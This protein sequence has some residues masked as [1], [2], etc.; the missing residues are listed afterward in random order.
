MES[1]LAS[2]SPMGLGLWG[3]RVANTPS[4][5]PPSRGGDT[6]AFEWTFLSESLVFWSKAN[7]SLKKNG[8]SSQFH[9]KKFQSFLVS[10]E[11]SS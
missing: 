1:S 3:E 5:S 7:K 10:T 11:A 6:F 8:N 4:F 2:V 9:K